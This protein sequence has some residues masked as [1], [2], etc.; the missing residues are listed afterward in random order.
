[1]SHRET[2]NLAVKYYSSLFHLPS[3]KL[4]LLTSYL[5]SL[6]LGFLTG[7]FSK[8]IQ[9]IGLLSGTAFFSLTL[10]S[11]CLICRLM[12][13]RDVVLSDLKRII[14][15]SA[16]SNLIFIVFAMVSLLIQRLSIDIYIKALSLGLFLTAS[17]RLL[18][19][20]TI[21]FNS[22]KSKIISSII[23]P[24]LLPIS[25]TALITIFSQEEPY[26]L[27]L[28]CPPFLALIFSILGVWLFT[29]SLNKEGRRVLGIPSLEIAKAFIAN[30]TEGVK[31]PFEEVLERLSIERDISIS[32]LIFRAKNANRL[33]A[34]MIVPNIHPGPFKNVGSSLLPSMIKEHLEKEFQCVVSV[35]H[36]VS[37]HELDLP[38]QAESERVVK[39]L[40]SS[41]KKTHDFSS[42]IT[43]FFM[44]EG[45]GAKVGC[46]IFN[47]CVFMTLTT[48]P[49]TMED[50]P[51]E[52]NDAIVKRA[53]ERGFSC[54]IVV[55]AHNSTNGP[56]NMERSVRVLEE[57]A[58]L[59]LER[60]KLLKHE[61][62]SDIRIGAGEVVLSD[63]GLKEGMGPGGI[64]AIVINVG[65]QRTA[66][67]TID[68]NNMISGLREKI[69]S[70]LREVSVEGGEIFTTDTHAVSAVVLNKRG[71]HPVGEAVDHERII[72]E[73]KKAVYKAIES[74]EPSEV[75]WRRIDVQGVKVI[76]ERRISELS[77]LTDS[78]F[79][80]AKKNSI[81]FAILGA[82]LTLIFTK[83]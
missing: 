77:L 72:N 49:E 23:Q 41:L 39:S 75:A 12:L 17:L 43:K 26:F 33:K 18:V 81:I 74:E 52:I 21:S 60:A 83:I 66:Y 48:S 10:L 67:V 20:D 51:L 79:R 1:M 8:N 69:L 71:Y 14:F 4:L 47:D 29:K 44:I 19:I 5:T 32:A 61:L 25:A 76:G 11:D 38:S 78:V 9:V 45:E 68:G 31:E 55:D 70:S 82:A 65:G 64:T 56:F 73:V 63:L 22:K 2:I 59:A 80:K 24:T 58:Y 30:W 13:K 57:T 40:L 42:K 53:V 36:G 50:L 62:S 46:Q 37:G 7:L 35:P 28:L 34:M 15:L 54:A 16:M 6:S 27:S 3:L